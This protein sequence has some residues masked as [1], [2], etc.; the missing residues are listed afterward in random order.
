M[1]GFSLL[2][3]KSTG[4]STELAGAAAFSGACFVEGG[5]FIDMWVIFINSMA[6]AQAVGGRGGISW[7]CAGPKVPRGR[8]SSRPTGPPRNSGNWAKKNQKAAIPQPRARPRGG[9]LGAGWG[10]ENQP[11]ARRK[12]P[13][14]ASRST[15]CKINFGP[16]SCSTKVPK[17]AWHARK[18]NQELELGQRLCA[19]LTK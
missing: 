11:A 19:R 13:R 2:Q 1:S 4:S 10:A 5:H 17:K 7:L 12:W 15:L 3:G 9:G 14:A 16:A 18:E 8:P 6:R